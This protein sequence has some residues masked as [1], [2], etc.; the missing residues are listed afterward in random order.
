MAE[1][2]APGVR[3]DAERGVY[4]RQATGLVRD[5]SPFSATLYNV[6][7]T[8]PGIGMAI[9][10]FWVLAVYPGAHIISAYWLTGLVAFAVAATFAFLAMAMPRSGGDYILVSRALGPPLGL[11]S[12]LGLMVLQLLATGFVSTVFVTVVLVPGLATIGLVAGSESLVDASTTLSGKT[13]TFLLSLAMLG[14]ALFLSA[15]RLKTA[16]WFQ[17]ISYV[18]AGAGS[19]VALI[20][21][22][23]VSKADFQARFDAV[24]GEGAYD[25]VLTAAREAGS[26]APGTS[27]ANT[28]PAIGA[29]ALFM[30]F[31]WW[32]VNYAGEIRA[33]RTGKT[34]VAMTLSIGIAALAYTLLTVGFFQMAGSEFV[35]A[36]NTVNGTEDYPLTVPP[37]WI[38]F[39]AI[40][41]EST[42]LAIFLIVTF[43]FWLPMWAWLQ[44]AQPIR[45]LFAWSFDGILPK[46]VAYVHPRTRAPLVALAITGVLGAASVAWVVYSTNFFTALAT[47]TLFLTIPLVLVGLSGVLLPF[48][49]PHIWNRTPLAIRLG[50]VPLLSILGVLCVAAG[51]FIMYVVLQYEGLGL[52]HPRNS[53]LAMAGVFVTAFALYYGARAIQRSRGY[54]ITLH[55]TEIPPE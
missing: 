30:L 44:L 3:Q 5:V 18:I 11:A 47:I 2:T 23:V 14:V 42:A 48:R 32:S 31:S 46:A 21:M 38:V 17:N 26:A 39:V 50:G 41:G 29:L 35:A 53:L 34:F 40:A 52:Q 4:V 28:V 22:F 49:R 20:T 9:S 6:L 55:Y 12:S 13:W 1:T 7:P 19:L 15:V 36:V 33:A 43:A 10:V 8:V 24:A 25:N 37:F 45:A 27:W 51:A 54:D 16:M